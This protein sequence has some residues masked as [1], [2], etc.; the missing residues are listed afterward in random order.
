MPLSYSISPSIT[1]LHVL[2]VKI[3]LRSEVHYYPYFSLCL[4]AWRWLCSLFNQLWHH[5]LAI[6]QLVASNFLFNIGAIDS[7]V[8]RPLHLVCGAQSLFQRSPKVTS[9]L[10]GNPLIAFNSTEPNW[11]P[12]LLKRCCYKCCCGGGKQREAD[13]G[14]ERKRQRERQNGIKMERRGTKRELQRETGRIDDGEMEWCEGV[15][16]WRS[17]FS[18]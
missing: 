5:L 16:E 11:N 13:R 14:R 12:C 7:T 10:Q 18:L 6:C 9:S 1:A 8:W 3:K 15:E 17:L 2:Y 4:K